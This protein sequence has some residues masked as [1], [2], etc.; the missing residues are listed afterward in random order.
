MAPKLRP[1]AIGGG[2]VGTSLPHAHR[3]PCTPRELALESPVLGSSFA[4]PSLGKATLRDPFLCPA[5]ATPPCRLLSPP[6]TRHW[7][8]PR[9]L[10]RWAGQPRFPLHPNL[11]RSR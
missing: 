8:R 2:E 7:A 9:P 10:S 5:G 1:S 3:A 6:P 4:T 11:S